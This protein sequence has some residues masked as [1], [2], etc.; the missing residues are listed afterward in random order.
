M[1][2]PTLNKSIDF[3]ALGHTHL[4]LAFVDAL[5]SYLHLYF[6]TVHFSYVLRFSI[7][8]LL[9]GASQPNK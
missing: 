1:L 2:S 7:W 9:K 8:L 6:F 5:L 3:F 4:V